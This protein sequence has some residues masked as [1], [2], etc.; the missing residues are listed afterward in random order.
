MAGVTL[1]SVHQVPPCRVAVER[2]DGSKQP[3][4]RVGR[5][6][7]RRVQGSDVPACELLGLQ[8]TVRLAQPVEREL[9]PLPRGRL[10]FRQVVL[11]VHVNEPGD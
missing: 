1:L 6:G 2:G 9:V 10:E 8:V 5:G 3:V 4:G 11:L 7:E